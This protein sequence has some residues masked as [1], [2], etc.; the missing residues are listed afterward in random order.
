MRA[1]RLCNPPVLNL[2]RIRRFMWP[3]IS[4]RSV[5]GFLIL[6]MSIPFELAQ[7]PYFIYIVVQKYEEKSKY[8]IFGVK[9][10]AD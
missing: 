9:N 8:E 4:K 3:A 2:V 10:A 5:L 6:V 1:L 7:H